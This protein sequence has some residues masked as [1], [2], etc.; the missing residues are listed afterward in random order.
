M[1]IATP[2]KT[3]LK[4]GF[5]PLLDCAPLVIAREKGF[6]ATEGL[7]VVLSRE[8]NWANIRDKVSFGLLDGAQ[9]LSP[10]PLA[11]TLGLGS[12]PTPMVT[13]LALSMN[14]NAVTLSAELYRALSPQLRDRPN[15]AEVGN[16]LKQWI[17]TLRTKPVFA[18]VYPY[19]CQHYQLRYWLTASG[20]NPDT[21]VTLIAVP[22][23]QMISTM[24]DRM[25][26]GYCAGEPWNSLAQQC[27][28]G[29]VALTGYQIWPDS[30]EKVFGVTQHWADAHPN[31]HEALIRALVNACEWLS[32]NDNH[33]EALELL[34]L[35]P[36]LDQSA[37]PLGQSDTVLPIM[38]S[39]FGPGVNC[40]SLSHAHLMLEQ[41][42][43][44]GQWHGGDRD[45]IA[46]QVYRHDI[47]SKALGLERFSQHA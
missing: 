35:P 30:I 12:R 8:S 10:M 29:T 17:S 28:E 22:P 41:M 45:Q 33:A 16:A 39:F 43:R 21:D 42:E 11:A 24:H 25:I 47:Y 27:G 40:P 36:Y 38:Q 14:G 15:P 4:L 18:T 46:R 44:W 9:M 7:N 6:F 34:R 37:I 2:E 3:A 13:G 20:I 5:V 23:T 31:T 26:D 1:S 32:H 19:S